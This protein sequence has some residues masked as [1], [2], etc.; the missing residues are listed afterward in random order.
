M[1]IMFVKFINANGQKLG[2]KDLPR[3]TPA[4]LSAS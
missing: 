4:V 1:E 3:F 2:M